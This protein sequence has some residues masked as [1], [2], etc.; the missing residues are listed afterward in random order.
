MV[1]LSS[2]EIISS[3]LPRASVEEELALGIEDEDGR[4]RLDAAG[5]R[6]LAVPAVAL[7]ILRPRDPVLLDVLPEM[8]QS[9]LLFG[10]VEADAEKLD[11]LLVVT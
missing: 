11:P 8:I 3:S 7:V 9:S 4:N 2:V 5:T 10:L 1:Y 6:E